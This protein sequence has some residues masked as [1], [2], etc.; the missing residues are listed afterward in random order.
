MSNWID[1]NSELRKHI[2]S[3]VYYLTSIT[4]KDS[5]AA[6]Y[7]C[8]LAIDGLTRLKSIRSWREFKF[9]LVARLIRSLH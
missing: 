5:V 7:Y 3:D 2:Y 8:A 9:W 4:F 1:H 6:T